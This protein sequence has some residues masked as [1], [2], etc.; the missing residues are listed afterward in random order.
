MKSP[1]A[2]SLAGLCLFA[3][4]GAA[5]AQNRDRTDVIVLFNGDHVTGE[6]KSYA[7]GRLSVETDSGKR[8]RVRVGPVAD[9]AAA[10]AMRDAL[11]SKLGNKGIIVANP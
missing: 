4:A 9:R 2:L 6:I 7:T 5:L 10:E 8:Y 11:G 1:R 3:L